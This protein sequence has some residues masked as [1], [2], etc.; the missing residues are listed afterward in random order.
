MNNQNYFT[1]R[2]DE[3][4]KPIYLA[5]LE[6]LNNTLPIGWEK[7]IENISFLMLKPNAYLSDKISEIISELKDNN[8]EVV[9]YKLLQLTEEHLENLYCF[10][11]AKYANSWWVMQKVYS[12]A[13]CLVAIVR[14]EKQNYD[15]LSSRI[16]NLVGS[17]TPII[18]KKGSIR[19]APYSMTRIFNT[20]HATDDP[21]SA[22]REALVFFTTDDLIAILSSPNLNNAKNLLSDSNI[23]FSNTKKITSFAR[24]KYELKEKLL[25][26]INEILIGYRFFSDPLIEDWLNQFGSLLSKEQIIIDQTLNL[27]EEFYRISPILNLEKMSII[28]IDRLAE[29]NIRNCYRKPEFL[30]ADQQ[31]V[32]KLS[33]LRQLIKLLLPLADDSIFFSINDFE[34]Y[35]SEINRSAFKLPQFDQAVLLGCWAGAFEEIRD[36][37]TKWPVEEN[38]Q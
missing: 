24:I 1:N 11:K 14:G 34:G 26:K 31:F 30:P 10:I 6:K 5:L 19:Y 21:A 3:I 9:T 7:Q 33:S 22:I 8:I 17:T 35:L 13:P 2:V 37:S 28:F 12:L 27:R 38:F 4:E 15:H 23:H 29:Q 25:R 20:I 18:S 16:R 36:I 32:D